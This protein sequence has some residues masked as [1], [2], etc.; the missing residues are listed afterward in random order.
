MVSLSKEHCLRFQ[1]ST[2]PQ[3]QLPTVVYIYLNNGRNQRQFVTT[4]GFLESLLQ[5][6]FSSSVLID[7]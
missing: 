1:H 7:P 3:A 6:G 2:T 4:S 5:P